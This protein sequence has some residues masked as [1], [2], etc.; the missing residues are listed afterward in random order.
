[1]T[2]LVGGD[3]SEEGH[4]VLNSIKNDCC[5]YLRER[6]GES[7]ENGQRRGQNLSRIP[8]AILLLS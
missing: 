7:I 2:G 1:M 3:F 6:G 5:S 4:T 8:K